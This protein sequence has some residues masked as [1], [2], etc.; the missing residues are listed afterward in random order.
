[1]ARLIKTNK[2][3][4][5][6]QSK[7]LE[8]LGGSEWEKLLCAI[9]SLAHLCPWE[10][11]Q[12]V[13]WIALLTERPE[14]ADKCD[15][16]KV[17]SAGRFAW[18]PYWKV[19][20]EGR[21]AWTPFL[22]ELN[23][24]PIC[25]MLLMQ[26]QLAEKCNLKFLD[27]HE[28]AKL[29]CAVPALAHL[30]PWEK[31]QGADWIVLLTERPEFTDRCDWN[32]VNS[33]G[34]SVWAPYP[35]ALNHP[36]ICQM[37]LMQP[38][39]VEKCDLK[40]LDGFC[41][42]T[43]LL[44]SS[45]R[46][47]TCFAKLCEWTK[48]DGLDWVV[49]LESR[50]EYASK[51]DWMKINEPN[52]SGMR[53]DRPSV[54]RG[55][56]R[57]LLRKKRYGYSTIWSL[58][59]EEIRSKIWLRLLKK[60]PQFADKCD[61]DKI[62]PCWS[63]LLAAQPQFA[64]RCDW[65][66]IQPYWAELLAAQ[67]QFAYRCDW[68]TIHDP[69][70][71]LSLLIA[72]PQFADKCNWECFNG[73]HW[74]RLLARWPQFARYC[75]WDKLYSAIGS[76][77][78][79]ESEIVPANYSDYYESFPDEW[80]TA[81]WTILLKYQPQF[82]TKCKW[83]RLDGKLWALLLRDLPQYAEK[84][85]WGKLYEPA[86]VKVEFEGGCCGICGACGYQVDCRRGYFE[87]PFC[88]WLV[89]LQSQ[90]QFADKCDWARLSMTGMEWSRLLSCQPQLSNY[91]TGEAWSLVIT[92]N[93]DMADSS[94]L[95]KLSGKDWAVLLSHRPE[96]ANKCPYEKLSFTE[97]VRLFTTVPKAIKP[98]CD[99]DKYF[100]Q[101]KESDWAALSC[102]D[103]IKLLTRNLAYICNYNLANKCNYKSF[104]GEETMRFLLSLPWFAKY[105]DINKL[106]EEIGEDDN[107]HVCFAELLLKGGKDAIW[108]K[109]RFPHNRLSSIKSLCDL[110]DWSRL[111]R[112]D[113]KWLMRRALD[114]EH[115]YV[116]C[117]TRLFKP[118]GYLYR[119]R[120]EPRISKSREIRVVKSA[121][122][123]WDDLSGH[124][125][126]KLL[127]NFPQLAEQ[128]NLNL[129]TISDWVDLLECQPT[130]A[131]KCEHL[132]IQI[133]KERLQRWHDEEEKWRQ[134]MERK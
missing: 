68:A 74:A 107:R 101:A 106:Y 28:W 83:D 52:I 94:T 93:P 18:T 53:S 44:K 104:S 132:K 84:C 1:M 121:S 12:G 102:A 128:C 125:I 87:K 19:N 103:W 50:P 57:L 47:E 40:L 131:D 65:D 79:E 89:L 3:L 97:I 76:D 71:W 59:Q 64:D 42:V 5:D 60:Q 116:V 127:K 98:Y 62:Q 78:S 85:D 61:W 130:L 118:K 30:C 100:S 122:L 36:P 22:N 88:C 48:L 111:S 123:D 129:L 112:Q 114:F 14:F 91:L 10:K 90:P 29:L 108:G 67:P 73:A 70:D 34:R 96:F 37:L 46:E 99:V 119:S 8:D 58:G 45:P 63:E 105:C 6:P 9:P 134:E 86:T 4:S 109:R 31:L 21:F 38:Q 26:P 35:N 16:N 69:N 11:L 82:D 23:H 120:D 25:Q 110:C 92:N 24:S 72:E 20:S 113:F 32:K 117:T 39:L 55:K 17:N 51:C 66:K 124:D 13:D 126:V 49:L 43:L 56:S 77:P 75:D 7:R 2:F 95:A 80:L 133:E 54:S 15:W 33:G 81:C 41:W 27:G 115:T